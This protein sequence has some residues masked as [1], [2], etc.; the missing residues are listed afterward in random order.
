MRCFVLSV[1]AV[2]AH[3]SY[4]MKVSQVIGGDNSQLLEIDTE[5]QTERVI[6]ADLTAETDFVKGSVVCGNTWY[7]I[8]SSMQF[9]GNVIAQV[10]ISTGN[11]TVTR[12]GGLWY[13]LKCTEQAN[14]LL[15]VVAAASP[16]EFALAKLTLGGEYPTTDIVGKFPAVLWDGWVQS[17]TFSGNELQ[18]NFAVKKRGSDIA[19]DGEVYRMDITTGNITMHKQYK[20]GFLRSSG[21]PYTI[22]HTEGC[23]Q[24]R[25]I[26]S[27]EEL[28]DK[29]KLCDVDYSG[30]D[31]KVT[32]CQKLGD[33]KSPSQWWTSGALPLQCSDDGLYYFPSEGGRTRAYEP[34]YG[35]DF[36][37][38][39][40]V[41]KYQFQG[42]FIGTEPDF[43][44]GTHTCVPAM[45]TV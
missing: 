32:N 18:A 33:W 2:S 36:A 17:F 37:S 24:A 1:V 14:E 22:L 41:E 44:I 42:S 19:K 20:A 11:L 26:F 16:P 30:T 10:D 40:V 23:M 43:Y 5:A 12:V 6:N 38:G 28:V 34:L 15:A 35:G 7:G 21:V 45:A 39:E 31:A 9:G 27:D 29:L 25:G 3:K 4:V 13:H 8:G